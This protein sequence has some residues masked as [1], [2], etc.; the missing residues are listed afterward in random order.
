MASIARM[1]GAH[2]D[3]KTALY[4][5]DVYHLLGDE[6]VMVRALRAARGISAAPGR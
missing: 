1:G 4:L 2:V 3:P 5:R 6:A